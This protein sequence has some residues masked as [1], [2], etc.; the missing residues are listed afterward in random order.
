[1]LRE[2]KQQGGGA[3]IG[4]DGEFLACA[5]REESGLGWR[6]SGCE[7]KIKEKRAGPLVWAEK[8]FF[9]F[10]FFLQKDSTNSI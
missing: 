6:G 3:Y 5:P 4:G 2:K 10:L 8:I 1:M 7:E 9:Y